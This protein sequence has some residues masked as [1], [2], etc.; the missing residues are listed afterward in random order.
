MI[1]SKF[2][3]T[4]RTRTVP[5]I[6]AMLLVLTAAGC[7][8]VKPNP[9]DHEVLA[10]QGRL[11]LAERQ[12]A[13]PDLVGTLSLEEAM[14]R[15]LKYNLE[16]RLRLLE[17]VLALNL[18]EVTKTDMLPTLMAR[19]GYSSRNNDRISLSRDTTVEGAPLIP[20]RF[21]SQERSHTTTELGLGWNLLDF[22]LGYYGSKQQADRVLQA[23]EKRRKAMHLLLQDV[24]I[25]YWRLASAQALE[26]QLGRALAMAEEALADARQAETARWRDPAEAMRYQRQILEN[27]RVLE[28]VQQELATAELELAQLIGASSGQRLRVSLPAAV[29][30][31]P[32]V[33]EWSVDEL[34]DLALRQNPD[35]R[36]HHYEA[37]VARLEARK[38]LMRLFP[39]LSLNY[40]INYDSDRYLL[41]NQWNQVGAQLGHN[42]LSLAAYRRVKAHGEVGVA[43]A[44]ERELAATM[45]VLAQV[46]LARIQ[47]A[48]AEHQLR[49]AE[50][51]QGVDRRLAD[52]VAN[53]ESAAALGRLEVVSAET[54]AILSELR[55]HQALAQLQAAEAR[56]VAV[57]GAEPEIPGVDET[58]LAELTTLLRGGWAGRL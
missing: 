17:E 7:M 32:V 57:L 56:L 2:S 4:G 16:H 51:I 50:D 15:A 3:F 41:N 42:L 14:A 58:S 23:M 35:L 27:L 20:S 31:S 40:S 10:V 28:A 9:V 38:A 18:L 36:V 25:A 19:A 30:L 21:I 47:L 43:L 55:H 26:E 5:T 24:R 44:E 49:R 53:R 52:L 8:S 39:N 33:G 54:V 46:H 29:G 37:R 34:E 12:A 11:S 45:A 22:G 6:I 13:I 48:Q 1:H